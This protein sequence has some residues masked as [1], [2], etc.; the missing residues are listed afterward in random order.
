[1]HL[2]LGV[3]LLILVIVAVVLFPY[4]GWALIV[5]P[6]AVIA[7]C[8]ALLYA[9]RTTLRRVARLRQQRRQRALALR[10]EIARLEAAQGI[11]RLTDGAC[12]SCGQPLIADARFC[13]Y[14][15]APTE[16]T[17]R[18]CDKCGTRNAGDAAWCGACG[19]ALNDDETRDDAQPTTWRAALAETISALLD[20][21]VD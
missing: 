8:V 4:Y 20:A 5:W 3:G 2:H 6:V 14:C 19:A 12:A 10:R 7:G 13:S 21:A 17:A 16:R 1:M 15:K 18:V 9:A 11:P